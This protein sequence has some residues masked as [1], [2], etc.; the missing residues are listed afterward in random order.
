M[1]MD[2]VCIRSLYDMLLLYLFSHATMDVIHTKALGGI[3]AHAQGCSAGCTL[4]IRLG[5]GS[6]AKETL[7]HLSAVHLLLSY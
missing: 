5:N 3:C 7:Q 4:S 6:F 1:L 2:P